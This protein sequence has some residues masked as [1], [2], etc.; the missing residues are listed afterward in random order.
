[1]LRIQKRG[2]Q[3]LSRSRANVIADSDAISTKTNPKTDAATNNRPSWLSEANAKEKMAANQAR[4][5]DARSDHSLT[6]SG[7]V[8]ICDHH[9]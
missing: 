6:R 8:A 4:D 5:P 7:T 3:E 9:S 1:M 2:A